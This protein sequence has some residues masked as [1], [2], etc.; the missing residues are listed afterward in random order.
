MFDT[1]QQIDA[2]LQPS[3]IPSREAQGLDKR[4]RAY[5]YIAG[6]TGLA[7]FL[8]T[9]GVTA[10]C[11][12][13]TGRRNVASRIEDRR[14]YRH[15]STLADPDNFEAQSIELAHGHEWFLSPI[16]PE[17]LAGLCLPDFINLIDGVLAVD[18]P[19]TVTSTA[20][21]KELAQALTPREFNRWLGTRD[22]CSRL[23]Q[24]GFNPALRLCTRYVVGKS[25][26]LSPTR[27]T[28]RIRPRVE[29]A[30]IIAA[31]MRARLNATRN[32]NKDG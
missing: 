26:R 6:S 30:T 24:V 25:Q 27:E 11:I 20:F 7:N 28:Y 19:P 8:K 29:M 5:V 32:Q 21:D 18:L 15:A 12:G 31:I 9:L 17:M 10:F 1:E 23:K 2:L 16:T 4:L 14:R 3:P 22:G 13:V